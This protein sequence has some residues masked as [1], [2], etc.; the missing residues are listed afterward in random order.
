MKVD[1]SEI[2][3]IVDETGNVIGYATRG[4]C[5]SGAKLLHPV[6]H[7]HVTDGQQS[8]L[9]QKRSASKDI[10]PG[11]WDTAVGGHVDFGETIHEALLRE[12]SEEI[13]IDATGALPVRSYIFE[14]AREREMV[15]TFMLTVGSDTQFTY[16]ADEIDALRFWHIDE[17]KA[18]IGKEIFTPNFEQEFTTIL[19]PYLQS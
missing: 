19:L 17:I 5:H 3:P 2:F 7:L 11:R 14:S 4:E 15:N 9:L 6:V 18:N 13:G 1:K 16:P 12:V 8:I 10:Q